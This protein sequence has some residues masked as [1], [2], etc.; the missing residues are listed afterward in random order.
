MVEGVLFEAAGRLDVQI[1]VH[2][3]DVCLRC[4]V[5]VRTGSCESI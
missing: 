5:L 3:Y 1:L 2:V 4:D